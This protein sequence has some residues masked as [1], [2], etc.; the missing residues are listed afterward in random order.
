MSVD[1]RRR[2]VCRIRLLASAVAALMILAVPPPAGAQGP[3]GTEVE[4]EGIGAVVAGDRAAAREDAVRDALRNAVEKVVGTHVSSETLVENFQLVQDRILTRTRGYISRYEVVGETDEGDLLRVRVRALVKETDLV[5]D[6]EAVGLLLARKDYPRLL[7]LVDEIIFVDEGNEERQPASVDAAVSSA[8]FME[9]LQA[10]G[11]RFVDPAVVAENVEANLITSAVEGDLARAAG[12]GRSY[13]ADVVVVG[14]TVARRN[15]GAAELLGSMVSMHASIS[16][17][18]LRADT[19][20]LLT[21][22][23]ESAAGIGAGPTDAA[24]RAIEQGLDRLVP[25]LEERLLERWS[26]D[27]TSGQVVE[28]VVSGLATFAEVQTFNQQL[29]YQVRGVDEVVLRNFVE[30]MAT[31]EIRM[32]GSARDLAS[33]LSR[34]EWTTHEV[35]VI[36][37]TANQVRVRVRPKGGRCGS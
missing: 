24:T 32:R 18:L 11:F 10:R 25:R 17:Q 12:L 29:S 26:Q 13:G 3:E 35:E 16:L 21:T 37:V 14:R 23:T 20:E 28:L 1:L 4:A 15:T 30:G 34:K 19:G 22:S 31:V 7:V 2:S 6:L 5:G 36:G 33:E 9:R 27:V 8:G